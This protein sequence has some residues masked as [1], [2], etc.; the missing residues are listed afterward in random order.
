MCLLSVFL[1]VLLVLGKHKPTHCPLVGRCIHTI[2]QGGCGKLVISVRL[3][4]IQKHSI[5]T[6]YWYTV[7]FIFPSKSRPTMLQFARARSCPFPVFA[8][9]L[10]SKESST[11]M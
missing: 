9:F 11:Y 4:S 7:V 2:C 1:F 8:Q 3:W 5:A 6:E 10:L